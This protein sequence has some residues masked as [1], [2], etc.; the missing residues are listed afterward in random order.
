MRNILIG[1]GF[2]VSIDPKFNYD[3]LREHIT[4]N[5]GSPELARLFDKLKSDDFELLLRKVKDAQDVLEAITDGHLQLDSK[6]SDEIRKGL[7][8]AVTEVLP[9]HPI[10]LDFDFKQA[11]DVLVQYNQVFT[12]N[13]DTNLYWTRKNKEGRFNNTDFFSRDGDNLI[14]DFNVAEV[15][16]N[17]P[18]SGCKFYF[19][20]GALFLFEQENEVYKVSASDNTLRRHIIENIVNDKNTILIVSEGTEDDKLAM[21]KANEYLSF[22]YNQL[23]AMQGELDIYGHGLNRDSDGHIIE[24]IN[25]SNVETINYYAYTNNFENQKN[26][27]LREI[28]SKFP[29]KTVNVRHSSEHGLAQCVE[30]FA[31]PVGS[32]VL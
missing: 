26:I 16:K 17:N 10:H 31:V 27:L 30:Q 8:Q 19:L 11:N 28:Q 9:E 18:L 25:D 15:S 5:G 2:S 4:E 14:F 32:E 22:C 6:I 7:K 3:S 1:N 23:R 24:A 13:Y 29:N 20:H 12:T 21:I